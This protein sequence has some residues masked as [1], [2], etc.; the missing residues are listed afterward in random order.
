MT[1]LETLWALHKGVLSCETEQ[2]HSRL[3]KEENFLELHRQD[4]SQ[5]K[6]CNRN[7][8]AIAAGKPSCMRSGCQKS[9]TCSCAQV[10]FSA[11]WHC[12]RRCLLACTSQQAPLLSF[13]QEAP[14]WKPMSSASSHAALAMHSYCTRS[15]S[16]C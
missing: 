2:H 4:Q 12:S 8:N 14:M 15:A 3:P 16:V 13:A 11:D 1:Q 7:I 6:C 10:T 9:P 5:H